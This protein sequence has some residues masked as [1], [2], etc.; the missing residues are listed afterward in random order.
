[1]G[2]FI[3]NFSTLHNFGENFVIWFYYE[4]EWKENFPFLTKKIVVFFGLGV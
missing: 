3:E 2:S 1:M 4:C